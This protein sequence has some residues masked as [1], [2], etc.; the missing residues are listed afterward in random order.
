[1]C[2]SKKKKKK[3]SCMQWQCKSFI[4]SQN[5]VKNINL[6][7]HHTLCMVFCLNKK[8]VNPYKL[9]YLICNSF[10]SHFIKLTT[11]DANSVWRDVYPWLAP[12]MKFNRQLGIIFANS[13][14]SL[15]GTILSA[16]PWTINTLCLHILDWW[17]TFKARIKSMN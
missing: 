10:V 3:K 8:N 15:R 16:D 13:S 2:G 6:N 11:I 7:P 1:M 5:F 17:V 14:A 9:S 4:R 12:F